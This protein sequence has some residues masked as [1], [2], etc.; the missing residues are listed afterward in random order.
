MTL[1][2]VIFV[3]SYPTLD[4]H[5]FDRETAR[6]AIMDFMKDQRKLKQ[7]IIVIVHGCG[8][9]ILK[10]TCHDV[11]RKSRFVLDFKTFYYNPGCTIV[12][13]SIDE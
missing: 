8:S 7:P 5:G 6:V 13:L 11:L 12:L 4:L 2:D 9:G 3:D 10:A 1:N